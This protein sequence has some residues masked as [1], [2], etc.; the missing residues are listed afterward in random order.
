MVKVLVQQRHLRLLH[1]FPTNFGN[2]DVWT[3]ARCIMETKS[4]NLNQQNDAARQGLGGLRDHEQV[5]DTT[6]NLHS[7]HGCSSSQATW[8]PSWDYTSHNS[9]GSVC[10]KKKQSAR[11]QHLYYFHKLQACSENLYLPSLKSAMSKKS[12]RVAK[13]MTGE[14]SASRSR[15]AWLAST[16]PL[17]AAWLSTSCRTSLRTSPTPGEGS[18]A[19]G[20]PSKSMYC[21][22]KERNSSSRGTM[23][24]PRLERSSRALI[25]ESDL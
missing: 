7:Q 17:M 12:R 25:S 8:E 4:I 13:T 6:V 22:A 2:N 24:S 5:H 10:R 23:S 20:E 3:W 18:I 9:H 19:W 1:C 11:K 15:P 21:F 16:E 14:L